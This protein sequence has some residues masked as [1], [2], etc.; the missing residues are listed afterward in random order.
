MLT[1]TLFV[2][3]TLLVTIKI[4]PKRSW[5]PAAL[6]K[7]DFLSL[8]SVRCYLEVDTEI[9]PSLKGAF[10]TAHSGS[11]TSDSAVLPLPLSGS[12]CVKQ[13]Y[14]S[15]PNNSIKHY[16]APVEQGYIH[17]EVGCLD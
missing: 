11:V 15:G 5:S 7:V 6:T 16:D 10:K 13:V 9:V 12:V 4:I 8:P 1:L 17:S 14:F 2:V 3:K